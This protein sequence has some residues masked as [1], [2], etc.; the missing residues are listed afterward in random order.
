MKTAGRKKAAAL[1]EDQ[2]SLD[3]L[4]NDKIRQRLENLALETMT[5]LE[6]MTELYKL[7]QML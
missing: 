1:P 5:P 7:K 3:Q 6:A 4:S 2:L